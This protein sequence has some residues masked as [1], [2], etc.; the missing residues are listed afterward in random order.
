MSVQTP[1]VSLAPAGHVRR[2]Y[3]R[4]TGPVPR[5]V[6][7][8]VL[9]SQCAVA[10]LGLVALVWGCLRRA[11]L[12]LSAP[13]AAGMLRSGPGMRHAGCMRH[14]A[15]YAHAAPALLP[16]C[17]AGVSAGHRGPLALW[18]GG[19]RRVSGDRAGDDRVGPRPDAAG[20]DVSREARTSDKEGGEAVVRGR[21]RTD[22]SR[23]GSPALSD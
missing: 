11:R 13:A 21:C 8:G 4:D 2:P 7:G 15:A 14:F 19:H 3:P 20:A 10:Q 12:G 18:A 17:G 6:R 23:A 5:G 22:A 16:R 1:V 9:V